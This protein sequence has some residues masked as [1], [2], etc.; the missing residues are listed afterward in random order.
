MSLEQFIEDFE[1]A[2]EDVEA[3]SLV[4]VTRYR[5]IEQW[6]SLAILTVVA[7]FDAEYGKRINAKSLKASDTLQELYEKEIVGSDSVS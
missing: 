3:G 7:M 2:V 1:E 5:D 6:D 4:P